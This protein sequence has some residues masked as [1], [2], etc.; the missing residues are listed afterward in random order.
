MFFRLVSLPFFRKVF[1]IRILKFCL[2]HFICS[3][4]LTSVAFIIA[5]FI[6]YVVYA[7]TPQLLTFSMKCFLCYLISLAVFFISFSLIQLNGATYRAPAVC[8]TVASLAYFSCLS[9]ATWSNA[10]SLDVKKNITK[11]KVIGIFSKKEQKRKEKIKLLLFMAYGWGVPALL[12]TIGHTFDRIESV[13]DYLKP[14]IGTQTCFLKGTD[15]NR[16]KF[17]SSQIP[18]E[19]SKPIHFSEILETRESKFLYYHLPFCILFTINIISFI[20][21][22]LKI[23]E[24]KKDIMKDIAEDEKHQF[25]SNACQEK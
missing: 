15:W 22:A 12:L 23:R 11:I 21:I 2:R 25:Q 5:T 17:I 20:L 10:I 19:K 16:I 24:Q 4:M 7:N 14:G 18:N 1:Y 3:V 9:T 8:Q 13:H 6:V